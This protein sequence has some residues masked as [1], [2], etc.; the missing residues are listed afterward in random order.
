MGDLVTIIR[1]WLKD[2]MPDWKVVRPNST[3]WAPNG[4]SGIIMHRQIPREFAYVYDTKVVV[5]EFKRQ[6]ADLT[7]C[8][9]SENFFPLLSNKLHIAGV[10]FKK[11]YESREHNRNRPNN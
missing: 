8:A 7:L 2:Q 11:A 9:H 6:K 4:V 1:E 3:F 5:H 10:G